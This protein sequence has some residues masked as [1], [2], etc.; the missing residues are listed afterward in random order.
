MKVEREIEIAAPAEDIYDVVM[1]PASPGGL[2]DASTNSW[3]HA[4]DGCARARR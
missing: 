2:G 3:R 1:D 4:P